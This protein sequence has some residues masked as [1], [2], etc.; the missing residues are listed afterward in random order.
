MFF[1]PTSK[2]FAN[3][4]Q[5]FGNS[6]IFFIIQ[7]FH[8]LSLVSILANLLV[9][10]TVPLIMILGSLLLVIS[11]VWLQLATIISLITSAFLAYFINI[12]YF[13]AKVPF[14]WEYFGEQLWIVWVGY[15]LILAGIL[16]T[17]NKMKE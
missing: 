8:Q 14:A 12:I 9:G 16:L 7:N 6:D 17:L 5:M 11:F 13:F 2:H 1:Y 4:R 15:Y 3:I 10:W